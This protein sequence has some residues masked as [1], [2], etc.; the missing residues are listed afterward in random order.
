MVSTDRMGT[1]PRG[2][3]EANVFQ[4][5]VRDGLRKIGRIPGDWGEFKVWNGRTVGILRM[6]ELEEAS[7]RME[8]MLAAESKAK[9]DRSREEL[10]DKDEDDII[11]EIDEPSSSETGFSPKGGRRPSKEDEDDDDFF[12]PMIRSLP[13]IFNI[14]RKAEGVKNWYSGTGVTPQASHG[15]NVSSIREEGLRDG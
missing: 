11:S 5:G 3:H 4:V 8:D 2:D 1:T 6:R 14:F 15:A 9:P 10:E 7:K 13:E 12:N